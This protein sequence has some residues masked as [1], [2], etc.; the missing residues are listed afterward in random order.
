MRAA[1]HEV[2][3]CAR[4][5]VVRLA[6]PTRLVAGA[7]LF[8]ACLIAP[9]ATASG[10]AVIAG[11]TTLWVVTCRVPVRMVRSTVVL[12]LVLFLPYF[13][14][15][16]LT[17]TGRGTGAAGGATPVSVP[18]GIVSHGLAVMLVSLGVVASLSKSDL[19]EALARLP[20]PRMVAAIL[21]QIVHQTSTL[22]AETRRIGT[23]MAVRGATGGAGA[24]WRVLV[25]LPRVWLPRVAD[26]AERVAAVM[27]LRGF[28]DDELRPLRPAGIGPADLA[29][30]VLTVVVLG[31]AVVVRSGPGR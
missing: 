5:P 19:R 10:L 17:S 22:F 3:G 13:L 20:V 29:G 1:W 12:G 4:G 24:A 31:V 14:L 11:T 21:L 9:G 25:S 18:L 28:C 7:G 30:L 6:P 27:E 23:A 26:R 16:P 8:A 15:V 2:W